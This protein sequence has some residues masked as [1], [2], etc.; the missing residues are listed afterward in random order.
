MSAG[1]VAISV[2]TLLIQYSRQA[3]TNTRTVP[4]YVRDFKFKLQQLRAHLPPIQV[5]GV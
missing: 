1:N 3:P 5:W 2:V 4:H